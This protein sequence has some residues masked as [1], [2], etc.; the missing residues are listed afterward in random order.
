MHDPVNELAQ[1]GMALTAE[2]RFRLVEL[3]LESLHESP[4][5]EIEEAWHL[6]IE[7]RLAEHDRGETKSIPAEDV[8]S[9]ARHIAR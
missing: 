7:R 1:R 2:E 3:L 4:V 9:K 6:E 5:A 8:F